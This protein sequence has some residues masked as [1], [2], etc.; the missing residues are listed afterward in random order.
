MNIVLFII[1][2]L[3]SS[4]GLVL[5]KLGTTNPNISLNLFNINLLFSIKSIIGIFCYGFSFI[6]W[7]IIVNRMNLTIAM[8]LSVALVNTLVIVESLLILNEKITILQGIGIFL[9]IVGVV[10]ITLPKH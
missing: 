5:F 4:S 1:Y 8:P 7:L 10:M 9:I 3:L 6:L 2:V